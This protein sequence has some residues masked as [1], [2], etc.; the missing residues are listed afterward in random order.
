M[1]YEEKKK[2]KTPT[3]DPN[4]SFMVISLSENSSARASKAC[5]AARGNGLSSHAR[6]FPGLRLWGKL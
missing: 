5:R 6:S 2:K 4:T 3:T 1:Q